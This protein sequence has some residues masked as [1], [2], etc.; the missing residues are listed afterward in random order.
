MANGDCILFLP[1]SGNN[2]F[3]KF[4]LITDQIIGGNVIALTLN[5]QIFAVVAEC[6]IPFMA[7]HV[8]EIDIADSLLQGKFPEPGQC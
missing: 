6:V 7:R 5:Q 4:A 2:G 1:N 8:T 3:A